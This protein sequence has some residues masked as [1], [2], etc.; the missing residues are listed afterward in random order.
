MGDAILTDI[1]YRIG[2]VYRDNDIAFVVTFFLVTVL[3]E[4]LLIH[5]ATANKYCH[6]ISLVTAKYFVCVGWLNSSYR[7]ISIR[8]PIAFRKPVLLRR[9]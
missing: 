7:D 9:R 8:F 4:F 1:E 2:L 5:H 6:N 3:F